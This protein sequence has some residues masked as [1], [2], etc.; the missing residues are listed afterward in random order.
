MLF[1]ILYIFYYFEDLSNIYELSLLPILNTIYKDNLHIITSNILGDG[2]LK[3]NNNGKEIKGNAKSSMTM[4][5]H[6]LDY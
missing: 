4:R 5:T 2:S 3:I 6:F 1:L